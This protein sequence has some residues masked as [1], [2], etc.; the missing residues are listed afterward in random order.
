M[1]FLAQM[2]LLERSQLEEFN[3]SLLSAARYEMEKNAGELTESLNTMLDRKQPAS[4]LERLTSQVK[5]AARMGRELAI[6]EASSGAIAAAVRPLKKTAGIGGLGRAGLGA[7]AGGLGGALH[8]SQAEVQGL[9]PGHH[10]RNALMGAAGGAALSQAGR[11]PG[12]ASKLM[13]AAGKVEGAAAH[14][15]P[16]IAHA[17]GAAAAHAVP[18]I[19]PNPS[20][21]AMGHVT[22][23]AA[24]AQRNRIK[25]MANSYEARGARWARGGAAMDAN[26]NAN[27]TLGGLR[28]PTNQNLAMAAQDARY[29]AM[30][31]PTIAQKIKKM[32]YMP[33]PVDPHGQTGVGMAT[34]MAGAA[35]MK[36]AFSM[37]A[38]AEPGDPTGAQEPEAESQFIAPPSRPISQPA[39]QLYNSLKHLNP[40]SMRGMQLAQP[41]T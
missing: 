37:S 26:R 17:P 32:P 2:K 8:H 14:A 38:Q 33:Q 35:F 7:L 31:A 40:R 41:G 30:P 13:G 6:K 22:D 27:P 28:G 4:H 1:N 15:A 9:A 10:L 39:A 29:D 3:D 18:H 36:R 25:Q 11:I 19:A 20:A 34:K 21:E 24:L 5:V 12:A 16:A 23:P